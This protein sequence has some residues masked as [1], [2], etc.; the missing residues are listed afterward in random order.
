MQEKSID[1]YRYR[2][3]NKLVNT[4]YNKEVGNIGNEEL[5]FKNKE[6]INIEPEIIYDKFS[7]NMKIEFKIGK[8]KM[9]KIKNLSEFY[10]RMI[11]KENYK[12]KEGLQFVHDKEMFTK[13]SQD[14]L[15]F[16]MKYAEMIKYA[17]SNSNSNYK[18]YGKA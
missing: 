16:I 14:L 3:F 11:N 8:N 4:L 2:N 17:N 10:T 15:D 5:E 9:Y 12:Y 6:T 7:G 13:E 18:Y 1:K